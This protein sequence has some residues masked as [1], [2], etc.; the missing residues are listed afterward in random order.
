[1]FLQ[2]NGDAEKLFEVGEITIMK[3]CNLRA[4]IE[5]H[6]LDNFRY[7]AYANKFL[8]SRKSAVNLASLLST[9]SVA[10]QHISRIFQQITGGWTSI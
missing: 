6:K 1:M 3:C 4:K 5:D 9:K 2:S 8:R 7:F 10:I